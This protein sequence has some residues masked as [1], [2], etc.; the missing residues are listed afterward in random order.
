MH[1]SE[2][3]QLPFIKNV[4]SLH[5]AHDGPSAETRETTHAPNTLGGL[6]CC[7][8]LLSSH[9]PPSGKHA[10]PYGLSW[11]LWAAN[12]PRSHASTHWKLDKYLRL[13]HRRHRSALSGSTTWQF[14]SATATA[15]G[16][17]SVWAEVGVGTAAAALLLAPRLEASTPSVVDAAMVRVHGTLHMI[18]HNPGSLSIMPQYNAST[19]YC[20]HV[21]SSLRSEHRAVVVLDVVVVDVVAAVDMIITT[22]DGRGMAVVCFVAVVVVVFVVVVVLF[23]KVGVMIVVLVVVFAVLV[24]V[25][26]VFVVVA[27]AVGTV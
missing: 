11:L 5:R 4:P 14:R 27:I 26:V 12:R 20:V 23:V 6:H 19:A 17:L 7:R 21:G 15:N 1:Q 22:A 13:R 2:L 25:V 18:G 10:R 8:G 9:K 16:V 3:T 24:V